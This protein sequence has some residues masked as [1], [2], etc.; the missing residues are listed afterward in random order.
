MPYPSTETMSVLFS[1]RAWITHSYLASQKQPQPTGRRQWLL[2]GSTASE[3]YRLSL[4]KLEPSQYIMPESGKITC[5]GIAPPCRSASTLGLTS[6][7]N[8]WAVWHPAME[9]CL[10]TAGRHFFPFPVSLIAEGRLVI[11]RTELL[12]RLTNTTGTHSFGHLSEVP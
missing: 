7:V 9:K 6:S 2:P 4:S 10:M 1:L 3:S 12:T 5:P 11:N 8:R